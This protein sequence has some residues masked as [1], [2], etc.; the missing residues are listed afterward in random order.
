MIYDE[1]L[2]NALKSFWRDWVKWTSELWRHR[3]F[4]SIKRRRFKSSL[5][6]CKKNWSFFRRVVDE[7]RSE[8]KNDR[9]QK[10]H[11]QREN[12]QIVSEIPSIIILCHRYEAQKCEIVTHR[13]FP[14][15]FS[16]FY[17]LHRIAIHRTTTTS[18]NTDNPYEM[19]HH[20]LHGNLYTLIPRHGAQK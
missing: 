7:M 17:R 4:K 2:E 15:L 5:E 14:A 12:C 18:A 19:I 8:I 13:Y 11:W 10:K 20:V 3:I 6:C 16:L 1:T 9:T